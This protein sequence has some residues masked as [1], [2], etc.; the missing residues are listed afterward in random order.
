MT[1]Q[2]GWC[3]CLVVWMAGCGSGQNDA[4]PQTDAGPPPGPPDYADWTMPNAADAPNPARY[5]PDGNEV[6]DDVTGLVW[7]RTPST[8]SFAFEQAPDYCERLGTSTGKLWRLPTRIEL[9]S[10]VDYTRDA[11]AIDPVA[12]P[13]TPVDFFWSSTPVHGDERIAWSVFFLD[14][15]AVNADRLIAARVRCVR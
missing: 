9:V 11:P 10:L 12:F 14:G 1:R 2:I 5:T 7:Q 13:D 8:D 15:A 4:S 6:V 3:L